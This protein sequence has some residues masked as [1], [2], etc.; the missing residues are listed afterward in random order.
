MGVSS[1]TAGQIQK[2]AAGKQNLLPPTLPIEA[3]SALSE[4]EMGLSS[5][6]DGKI[7]WHVFHFSRHERAC[8]HVKIG[9]GLGERRELPQRGLGQSPNRQRIFTYFRVNLGH[10][11]E[12]FRT[13][14]HPQKIFILIIILTSFTASS[15]GEIHL[16]IY[17]MSS[18]TGSGA[19]PQPPTHFHVF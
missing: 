1:G 8:R 18:Q 19:E 5:G 14:F 3:I 4:E 9:P 10:F 15:M 16:Y 6:T 13:L 12:G 2:P 7:S 11:G 17:I